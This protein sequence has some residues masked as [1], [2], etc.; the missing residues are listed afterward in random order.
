MEGGVSVRFGEETKRKYSRGSLIKKVNARES[1]AKI[2]ILNAATVDKINNRVLVSI[3]QHEI[4]R[5]RD[6]E[7]AAKIYTY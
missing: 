3:K 7:L 1:G 6:L 4:E 2:E 5:N